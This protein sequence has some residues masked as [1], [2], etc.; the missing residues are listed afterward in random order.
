[1]VG[2]WRLGGFSEMDKKQ[3]KSAKGSTGKN[4][5]GTTESLYCLT[6]LKGYL[7]INKVN[8]PT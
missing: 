3:Q 2:V 7:N 4:S 5:L 6:K 8:K 1:M